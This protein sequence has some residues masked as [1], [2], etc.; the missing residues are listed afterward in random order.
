MEVGGT[1][2]L[3]GGGCTVGT[4]DFNR[5]AC[6]EVDMTLERSSRSSSSQSSWIEMTVL[7]EDITGS[8]TAEEIAAS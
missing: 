6:L 1:F 4:D 2:L 8:L 5:G 3:T 7:V